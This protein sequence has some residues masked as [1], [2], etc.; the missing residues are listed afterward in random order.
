MLVL[1]MMIAVARPA[2]AQAPARV[3]VVS[4]PQDGGKLMVFAGD[5]VEVRLHSTP[6]T[7]YSWKVT[8]VDQKVLAQQ[9]SPK[10]EPPPQ[11]FPGAEGHQIFNF[12][13]AAPGSSTLVLA[14][15]R[16]WEKGAAPART[17]SIEVSVRPAGDRPMPQP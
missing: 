7:G 12:L 8:N 15:S 3:V 14:Y 5:T 4:D 17:F 16:P 11:N 2:N 1:L 9:G 6:S 10:F 13:A